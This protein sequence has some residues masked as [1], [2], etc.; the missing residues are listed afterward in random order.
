MKKLIIVLLLGLFFF[1]L[2]F[3]VKKYINYKVNEEYYFNMALQIKWNLITLQALEAGEYNKA[4]IY[5][6]EQLDI[7]LEPFLEYSNSYSGA[8]EKQFREV[9]SRI[10]V[11]EK[12]K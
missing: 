5:S 7:L 4:R 10:E 11:H 6:E 2:F 3:G 12:S 8:Y 9:N 1:S